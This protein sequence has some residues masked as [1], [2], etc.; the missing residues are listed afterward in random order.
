MTGYYLLDHPNPAAVT[1]PDGTYWGR[2]TMAGAPI[3]ITVHT[4]ESF[5]DLIG[6]DL[7]AENVAGYFSRSTTPAS[8]HTIVDADSKVPLLP[9][10]L[11][12]LPVH[13]AYHCATGNTGN[14]GLAF[15]CRSVEWPTMPADYRRRMLS[16]GADVAADW[17]RAHDIP[18]RKIVLA[19]FLAKVPGFTGHGIV[20]P[21]DRSDP[22]AAVVFEPS[23]F[24]WDEFLTMVADR[25]DATDGG[26]QEET[27]MLQHFVRVIEGPAKDSIYARYTTGLLV[28]IAYEEYLADNGKS[29]VVDTTTAGLNMALGRS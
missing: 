2:Q 5:A 23:L 19:Q 17:V 9:A 15:A 26:A 14:L 20:Q 16:N 1:N 28:P 25:L 7:G 18:I 27:F 3:W 4:A 10:G 11:D 12:E 21:E 22:G 8:Y 24:P 6:D 13:V 29:L